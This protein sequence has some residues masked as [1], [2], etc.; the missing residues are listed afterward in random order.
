ML[1]ISGTNDSFKA[2]STA[3]FFG[4]FVEQLLP[5]TI[6]NGWLPWLKGELHEEGHLGGCLHVLL[7][8]LVEEG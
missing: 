6:F 3:V 5:L 4:T 1:E 2:C 7:T 8:R